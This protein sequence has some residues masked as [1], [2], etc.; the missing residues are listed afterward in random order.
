MKKIL[1][2]LVVAAAFA[3]SFT[4]CDTEKCDNTCT[5]ANDGTCDDGGSGSS[6]SVCDLGTDCADCG[7]R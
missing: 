3:F 7:P 2:T 1:G 6:F 5:W 4:S